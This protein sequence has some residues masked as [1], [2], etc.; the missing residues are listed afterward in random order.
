MFGKDNPEFIRLD[1]VIVSDFLS[2][3][4]I[5]HEKLLAPYFKIDTYLKFKKFERIIRA[6]LITKKRSLLQITNG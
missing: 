3:K 5:T 6:Q 2:V 1:T 4:R